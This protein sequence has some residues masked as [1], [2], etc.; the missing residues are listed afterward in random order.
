[1]TRT[2]KTYIEIDVVVTYTATKGQRGEREA[3]TGLQ[4]SPDDDDE[5]EIDSVKIGDIEILSALPKRLV[6]GLY[7]EV[8]DDLGAVGDDE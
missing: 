8:N 1:M 5:V 4:L 2:F 3:G 6:E 7:D